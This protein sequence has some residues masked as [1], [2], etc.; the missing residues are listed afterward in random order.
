MIALIN[1]NVG[2]KVPTTSSGIGHF[3]LIVG[4]YEPSTVGIGT[5][6]YYDPYN[7]PGLRNYSW[8]LFLDAMKTGTVSYNFLRI[9]N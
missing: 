7:N 4:L 8:S 9:G 3:V 1:Y 6:Y 2:T 5:V